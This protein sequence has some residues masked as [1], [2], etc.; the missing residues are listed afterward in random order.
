LFR[1]WAGHELEYTMVYPLKRVHV[2]DATSF[3]LM[4]KTQQG[5]GNVM[6]V[7][8]SYIPWANVG[9]YIERMKT[10]KNVHYQF[11]WR[12][13][14]QPKANLKRPTIDNHLGHHE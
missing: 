9:E 10:N 13:Y 3:V 7:M 8:A 14:D 5:F 1:K 2:Q 12:Q 11:V 6:D 4:P